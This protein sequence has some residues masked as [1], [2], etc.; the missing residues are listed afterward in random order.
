MHVHKEQGPG[1]LFLLCYL[2]FLGLQKVLVG[3][4]FQ[5]SL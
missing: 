4:G 3:L 1:S 2:A 5:A